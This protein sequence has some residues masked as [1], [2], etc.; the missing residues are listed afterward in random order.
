MINEVE[1]TKGNLTFWVYVVDSIELSKVRNNIKT[2]DP[3]EISKEHCGFSFIDYVEDKNFEVLRGNYITTKDVKVEFIKDGVKTLEFF[4]KLADSEFIVSKD[5]MVAWGD[6]FAVELVV[7]ELLK[8]GISST[9]LEL[10]DDAMFNAQNLLSIVKSVSI[11]N[12][13]SHPIR[14]VK[15]SGRLEADDYKAILSNIHSIENISGLIDTVQGTFVTKIFSKGKINLRSKKGTIVN[16][17][18]IKSIVKK[19]QN[20]NEEN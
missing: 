10:D 7:F 6:K 2:I 15:L 3:L 12:Q 19:I 9:A 8:L 14:K 16:L 17:E 20:G 1:L 4:K 5:F 11:D 13:K 18:T